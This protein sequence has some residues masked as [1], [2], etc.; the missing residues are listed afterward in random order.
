MN[1]RG[2]TQLSSICYVLLAFDPQGPLG[3]PAS[4]AATRVVVSTIFGIRTWDVSVLAEVALLL[5]GAA[6]LAT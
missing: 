6:L 2:L 3:V 4:L 5:S 1:P